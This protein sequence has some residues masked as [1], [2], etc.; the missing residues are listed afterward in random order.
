MPFATSRDGVKLHYAI[1]DYTDPWKKAP[2][3]I[4][5]H[6]YA[7]NGRFWYLVIPY[8]ARFYRVVCPDLRGHGQS[9]KDFDLD[10][11]F[12]VENFTGDVLAVADA[13]GLETFHY[14]ADSMGGI[15]GMALAAM[16]S[17]RLRTL[18]IMSSPLK[19][20]PDAQDVLRFGYPT[21]AEAM[22]TMGVKG[23]SAA[24]NTTVRFPPGTDQG[25]MDWYAEEIGK[26]DVE[27]L[28]ATSKFNSTVDV[29]SLLGNIKTPMLALYPSGG[30]LATSEHGRI[31]KEKVANVQVVNLP[32]PYHFIWVMAPATCATHLLHFMATTDGLPC[33]E[34]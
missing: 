16:H 12:T 23:W 5:Q 30:K 34:A 7:R 32:N 10:T 25:L 4:L 6:G 8:L 19:I 9:S 1:H 31:L 26:E 11:G 27:V 21:R 2:T 33:H 15:I 22:R 28:I 29:T 24:C 17:E 3:L 13:L 14:A 18:T 20:N